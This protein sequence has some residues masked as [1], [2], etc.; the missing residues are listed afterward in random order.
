MTARAGRSAALGGAVLISGYLGWDS[1]LWDAR[2]QLGLHL[3]AALAIGA[4]VWL[5][6][7][8]RELPRTRIDRFKRH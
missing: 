5:A 3:A 7:R 2:L 1:P 8:G 6:W 4:L